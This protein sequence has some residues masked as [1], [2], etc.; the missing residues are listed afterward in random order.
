MFVTLDGTSPLLDH[1]DYTSMQIFSSEEEIF[2][3]H[4]DQPVKDNCV[5]YTDGRYVNCPVNSSIHVHVHELYDIIF[6]QVKAVYDYNRCVRDT[7]IG[8]F[9]I[10]NHQFIGDDTSARWDSLQS[11]SVALL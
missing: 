9:D 2:I 7:I 10:P 6:V 8:L 5:S 11:T 1:Y 4:A 3:S